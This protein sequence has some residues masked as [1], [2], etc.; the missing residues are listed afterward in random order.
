MATNIKMLKLLQ[1][2]RGFA[3]LAQRR[4]S[5]KPGLFLLQLRAHLNQTTPRRQRLT[6]PV[7]M[8]ELPDIPNLV[9]ITHI[10]PVSSDPI[11]AR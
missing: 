9:K 7:Q 6:I 5:P 3:Q 2:M 1:E 8:Y 10:T 4:S 11:P